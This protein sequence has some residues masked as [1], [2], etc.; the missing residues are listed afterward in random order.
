MRVL[1]TPYP[2]KPLGPMERFHAASW[3]LILPHG[4]IYTVIML[5]YIQRR[6]VIRGL[7]LGDELLPLQVIH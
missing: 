5:W 4:I 3:P 2:T 7:T 1:S 6:L